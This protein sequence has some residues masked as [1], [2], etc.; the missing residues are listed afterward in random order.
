MV[1]KYAES[2]PDVCKDMLPQCNLDINYVRTR[3]KLLP[4]SAL[5]QTRFFHFVS[6]KIG[7]AC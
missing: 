4:L 3:S 1:A 6:R 7:Q 5:I 2:C